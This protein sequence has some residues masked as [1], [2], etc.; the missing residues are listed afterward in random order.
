MSDDTWLSQTFERQQMSVGREL[1][2]IFLKLGLQ[3]PFPPSF[4][5]LNFPLPFSYEERQPL[6][7]HPVT[8]DVHS[9]RNAIVF[10]SLL[11]FPSTLLFFHLL[12]SQPPSPAIAS[13]MTSLLSLVPPSLLLL[14]CQCSSLNSRVSKFFPCLLNGF[15]ERQINAQ[16]CIGKV[17]SLK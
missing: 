9:L 14:S 1:V 4:S 7:T 5:S 2:T 16:L 13:R 10:I 17:V 12:C 6:A 3:H 15:S 11:L 8:D